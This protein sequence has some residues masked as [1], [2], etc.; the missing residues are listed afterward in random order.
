MDRIIPRRLRG[1]VLGGVAFAVFANTLGFDFVYDDRSQI[2]KNPWIWRARF[3]PNLVSRA[4]W[5]FKGDLPSNYY[6]PV[7]TLLYFLAAHLG[8]RHPFGFHLASV[9]AH[10]L[11][12]GMAFVLLR[13]MTTEPRAALA[14]LLFAVHP[15]HVESVA[16]IAGSTDVNCAFLFLSGL[17]VWSMA[18]ESTGRRSTVL[19]LCFGT[20]F[21]LALWAKETAVVMPVLALA[22]TCAPPGAG[23]QPLRR[24]A[25][26]RR[27]DALRLAA[28]GAGFFG[29]YLALRLAALGGLWTLN[30]HPE[31]S[32]MDLAASGL[33]LLPRYCLVAFFPWNLVPDRVFVPASGLSDPLAIGGAAIL[34]GALAITVAL[35]RTAP[36]AAFAI[37][38]FIL[39]LLPVLQVQYVGSNAQADRYLYIPALG[40]CLLVV[41]SAAG[42]LRPFPEHLGKKG[43][44][45]GCAL[46][47]LA[48]AIRT[49]SASPMWRDDETLAKTG[50]ALEPRSVNMRLLLIGVLDGA[51]R[52]EEA[53]R[54]AEESARLLPGDRLVAASLA[55]MRAQH[56][57]KTPQE[58][59]AILQ[60]AISADPLHPY[61]WASL[62][63]ACLRARL[64]ERAEA[65][66][67]KSLRLD[68]S[69][70][71]AIINLSSARGALGDPAGQEKE[72]RRA[73]EIDPE[74]TLAWLELGAARLRQND[75]AGFEDAIRRAADRDPGNGRAHFYL[76]YIA[77]MRHDPDGAMREAEQAVRLEP[78]DS[79]L[80][81][82]IG[83]LRARRGEREAAR[84]AWSRA[85][86]LKPGDPKVTLW[87]KRLGDAAGGVSPDM[88]GTP[89]D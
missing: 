32:S 67:E 58:Q 64:Y 70:V 30:R 79:S 15:A 8:G 83:V 5:S 13:R 75:F 87:L 46:L 53:F 47:A 4:V 85:L 60:T 3:L 11:S 39:P 61:L 35:R 86:A 41:E 66:A 89:P 33:A 81:K 45:W 74:S 69:G 37:A 31:L 28:I 25:S 38:L 52:T 20:L 18:L 88:E 23:G 14:S 26:P 29:L 19:A 49:V 17:V 71:E 34:A 16:W 73:L 51:G 27:R 57:A 62:S 43:L 50:I 77:S 48:A 36:A 82:W 12:T 10:A 78:E 6:R 2:L 68:P 7:Q 44:V 24:D 9:L 65:A 1:V 63:A 76:S 72:A 21:F 80:W 42:V 40:A 59:I 55:G 22:L 56:D 54:V 84:D